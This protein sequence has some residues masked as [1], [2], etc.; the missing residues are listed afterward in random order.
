MD[1]SGRVCVVTGAGRGIGRY[2]AERFGR[3]GATLALCSR[4]ASDLE[5]VARAV[6]GTEVEAQACD[7]ADPAQVRSFAA[8]VRERF[9]RAD[10]LV[11]CAGIQGPVG[12]LTEVDPLAWLQAIQVN[13]LGVVHAVRAFAPLMR[14]TGGGRIITMS[15][16]GLGG[17]SLSS[18]LSAYTASKAAVVSLTETLAKELADDGILINALAPGAINTAFVDPVVAAGPE[19]AGKNLYEATVRQRAGGDPIEKVGDAM[20]FLASEASAGITGRLISAKWDPL[21]DVAAEPLDEDRYRLRRIDGVMF[22]R[23]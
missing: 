6:A 4:T 20:L 21:A 13:L 9:G 10:V 15:G 19:V 22:G 5:R 2:T 3:S 14:E 11:N 8:A 7:V 17:S 18:R 1:L 16:G 12:R 23:V